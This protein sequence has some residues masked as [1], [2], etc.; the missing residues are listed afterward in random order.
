MD[1]IYTA[2]SPFLKVLR[3]F[4]I[5]PLAFAGPARKGVFRFTFLDAILRIFWFAISMACMILSSFSL[6][7]VF[8]GQSK[9]LGLAW[10][11]TTNAEVLCHVI[12]MLYQIHKRK[13]ILEALKLLNS[14]DD[15]VRYFWLK[16]ERKLSTHFS[17]LNN[18]TS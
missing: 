7:N 5:F 4:G 3:I 12:V 16:L 2:A 9:V 17:R 18:S 1:N 14:F 13:N 8:L 11:F 6:K 10:Y 15:S